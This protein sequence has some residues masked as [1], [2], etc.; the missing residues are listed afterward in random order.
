MF[1]EHKMKRH[2]VALAMALA[3]ASTLVLPGCDRT[4]RLSEQEHI[5]RAKD[6]ED[7][8]NLKGSI[9]ELKNALQ[10]NPDSAQARLLL[11]QVY[12]KAGLGAEAEK[13]LSHAKKLGVSHE[14][15]KIQL[16][17]ALLLMGENK[18]VLDEIHPD[19]QTTRLNR[20]RI[21]QLQ[22]DALLNLGQ[23]KDACN[24]FQQ[25]LDIDNGNPATYWGLAQCAAAE[26]DTTKAREW[27][28]AALKSGHK[29]ARTW[30]LVGGIEQ[31][32]K[33]AEAA[34]AAYSNALKLEPDNGEA[35]LGRATININLG[36]LEA[37]RSDIDRVRKT[38]PNS[39]GA[40]YLQALL[41]YKE[42]NYPEA[43]NALQ[44]AL[45]IS[46]DY[47]PALLLGGSIE[48]SLNNLQTAESHIRKVLRASPRNGNALRLLAAIQL[49]QGRT[50]D[51]ERTL[52]PINME[53][54]K[55]AGTYAVAGEIALAQKDF[56]KAAGYFEKAAELNPENATILTELGVAR[57]GMGDTRAMADLQAAADAGTSG[58]RPDN[59]IILTQ[60]R[61]KQFDAALASIAELEKKQ[62]P[63]PLAWNYRGAAY[64]GKKDVAKARDS[65]N[66]ALKLDPTFFPAIANLA[67]LDLAEG[68]TIQARKRFESLL[69]AE[70]KHLPSMLA[71]ADLSRMAGDEK[72]HV[73]WLEDAAEAH[74]QAIRPRAALARLHLAR[75]E[76]QKA[77]ARSR[78]ALDANPNSPEALNLMGSTQLAVGD[79][80]NAI[81]TFTKLTKRA[82]QSPDA[83][84]RLALAQIADN[85]MAAAQ[86]TLKEALKLQPDHLQSLNAMLRL[87][88][89]EKK[90]DE[91]IQVA[92]QIQAKHPRSPIGFEREA[93]ILAAQKRWSQAI[94]SY[95]QAL[96][97]DAGSAGLI[98]LF[99]VQLRAGDARQAEQRIID[100]LK[101]H[102]KDNVVR[103]HAAEYYLVNDRNKDAIAQYQEL[104]RQA[105]D[106]IIALNNLAT[107]YHR[108]KD[109]RAL[110]TAEQALK[111]APENPAVRDTLG[112]IL[113]EQGQAPRGL[114]LLNKA[115]AQA[116]KAAAVRYHHAVALAR[117]GKRIEAREE[118]EKLLRDVPKFPEADAARAVLQNL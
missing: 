4:A 32:N 75:K 103:A 36:R 6:F 35:L 99:Q 63:S 57:M 49:R 52:A 104:R 42:K 73:R 59:I 88:L 96:N 62:G 24:L 29:Q 8:Q 74:P 30:I 116:P 72:S 105:P 78:E 23:L 77:L 9:V 95:E 15:I 90:P 48:F 70:P 61:Q 3:F 5:Q 102:P 17:E 82:S 60:L 33:D 108:E 118:L 106:N 16:G 39:L 2:P 86:V 50:H 40:N 41:K 80:T 115:L 54:S 27:L 79:R 12:L 94:K 1:G 113:V 31:L 117:T 69:K 91:A 14:A 98:K 53:K 109:T 67:Q 13:E 66:Q 81:A 85:K 38:A 97:R 25:S 112:W 11:G 10:K 101:L 43:R 76:P 93:D 7:K 89:A 64:Q 37:A 87:K 45:K 51:A 19:D 28:D 65:F 92:R 20:A 114:E 55:D 83:Y 44:E 18:R 110:E 100:W 68:Q 26:R 71:L 46:P 21:L 58:D 107:L 84:L 34:L 47:L 56:T 111:L 22:A